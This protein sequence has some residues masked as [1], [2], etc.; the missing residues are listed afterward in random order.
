MARSN[1][2]ICLSVTQEPSILLAETPCDLIRKRQ[3]ADA[4]Q[5]PLESFFSPSWLVRTVHACDQL[6]KGDSAD[7][8]PFVP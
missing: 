8:E 1:W 4:S 5:E 7:R 3:N 6:G 2:L